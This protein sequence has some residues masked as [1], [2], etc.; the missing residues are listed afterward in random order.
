VVFKEP[1]LRNY[2]ESLMMK[3]AGQGNSK[4]IRGLILDALEME[5][6]N[7][8]LDRKYQAIAQKE[9]RHE[10]FRID[11]AE[12]VLVAYG[13]A[14]RIA[15]GAIKRMRE[16]GMRVGL[17]RPISLW[18]FPTKELREAAQRVKDFLVFELSTGQMVEDVRLAIQG[19]ARIG[20]HGRP[21]GPIPTPVELSNAIMSRYDRKQGVRERH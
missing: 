5:E 11:D 19:T 13:T 17:F 18:P 12:L 7:W 4:V 6:H 15:K 3:G 9:T 2:P 10:A 16:L 21:G 20:F 8:T 14:A 1:K